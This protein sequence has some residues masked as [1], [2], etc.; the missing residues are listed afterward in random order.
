[1]DPARV[2]AGAYEV[3]NLRRIPAP[4]L[5]EVRSNYRLL[6][7]Q[8]HPDKRPA[9]VGQAEATETFQVLTDAYRV[10]V[11]DLRIR[12]ADR[13]FS[14]MR[15]ESRSSAAVPDNTTPTPA[16]AS[17]GQGGRF[18]L[19][20]FNNVFTE[21]RVA[22]ADREEGYDEWMAQATTQ[23]DAH[24]D[25]R[26]RLRRMQLARYREPESAVPLVG[27]KEQAFVILGHKA[28]DYSGR[29]GGGDFCD[30]KLAHTTSRLVDPRREVEY[31]RRTMDASALNGLDLSSVEEMRGRN[32]LAP[33][34]VREMRERAKR[35]VDEARAEE[36]RTRALAER[37]RLMFEAHARVSH[38]LTE[39][40]RATDPSP[41]LHR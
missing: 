6:A 41:L 27:R 23:E 5:A 17:C 30:Y 12:A 34:S 8:L 3:L 32:L 7:K 13:D 39:P 1:M 4:D 10:V 37:D 18:D 36:R 2:V 14:S 35:D 33:P 19:G 16:S 40:A 26:A 22:S 25:E 24:R 28:E 21:S 9:G 38:L 11:D 31:Q 15:A 29:V 20:R